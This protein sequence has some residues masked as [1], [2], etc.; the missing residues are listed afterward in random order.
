MKLFK[1]FLIVVLGLGMM[2]TPAFLIHSF[3]V[4]P[5]NLEECCLALDTVLSQE[6]KDAMKNSAV[7]DPTS[8][9][10]RASIGQ[11]GNMIIK[12][13]LYLPVD[14]E[15]GDHFVNSP[16]ADLLLSHGVGFDGSMEL[17]RIMSSVV[18]DC[19]RHYLKG[20][21]IPSIEDLVVDYWVNRR[22][23]FDPKFPRERIACRMEQWIQSKAKSTDPHHS[24]D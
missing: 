8:Y 14:V 4:T 20:E 18:L 16:L 11:L 12:E 5:T 7:N 22:R 21:K 1:K 15:S 19:Y 6:E 23:C 3:A 9:L 17:D 13:W 10:Y 2:F 24:P